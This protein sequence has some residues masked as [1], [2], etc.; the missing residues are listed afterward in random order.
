MV[1][2]MKTRLDSLLEAEKSALEAVEDAERKARGIR[3]A[4]P[5]QIS[6]IEE[7]Y[8]EELRK[9]EKISLE[10][11]SEE[12]EELRSRLD[13]TL[14]KNRESLEKGSSVLAPRALQLIR[15]A[16]EGEGG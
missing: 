2:T 4:I 7:E 10:K 1:R 15:S 5:G 11:V 8:E 14:E 9:Y 16:V 3:T 12:I 13:V 6:A